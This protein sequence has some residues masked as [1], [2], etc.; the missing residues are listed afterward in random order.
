MK[1]GIVELDG[2]EVVALSDEKIFPAVIVVIQKAN[3]PSGVQHS[4]AG[5]AGAEAGVIKS[6]VAIV[7]VERVALVGKIGDD[8]VRPTII[9]IVGK[10]DAHAGVGAA[11][12]VNGSLREETHFFKSSV[13]FVVVEIFDHR[14]VG[15]EQIDVAVA[16]IVRDGDAETFA[17]FREADFLRNLSKVAVAVIVIDKR[18]DGL[19]NVGMTVGA[20]TFLVLA[21]P[22]IVEIPLNVAEDHEVE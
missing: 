3:A 16:I 11:V 13:A 17:R 8:Q 12:A 4:G 2:V 10:V 21:A 22:D 20:E 7:L 9:V 19:K 14:I 5:D 6:G 1:V 18:G 15:H